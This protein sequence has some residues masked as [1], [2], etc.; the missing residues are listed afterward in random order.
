MG[1]ILKLCLQTALKFMVKYLSATLISFVLLNALLF[2]AGCANII[3]PAGGPMDT[4]P[5]VLVSALP[6]DSTTN[7]S[8][9]KIILNF[10]EYIDLQNTF[11]NVLISPVPRSTPTI[12]SNFKSVS[13]KLKDSLEPNT[14]YTI[15]FGNSLRDINESNIAK[16]FTYVFSTGSSIDTNT[17]RGKVIM[18]ET[19]RVDST[20]IVVLHRNH[21]D[22]AVSL[23][24]P[25]YYARVDGNGMFQFVNLPVSKFSIY[26]IPNN[27]SKLYEDSTKPFAFADSLADSKNVNP[28]ILYAYSR[29]KKDTIDKSKAADKSKESKQV[30][31][32]VNMGGNKQDIL[33]DLSMVFNRKIQ[34]LDSSKIRL[35]DTNYIPFKGY[36]LITDTIK[37]TIA[38]KINWTPGQFY[39]LIIDSNAVADLAGNHL[40]RNDTINFSAKKTDEYGSLK[41]RFTNIDL[42]RN[43]VLQIVQ[44]DQII[45]SVVVKDKEVSKKLFVPGEYDLRILYDTN[46]NGIWDAGKFFGQK[47]QPEIVVPIN[48]KLN[49]RANWDNEKNITL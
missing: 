27:Y 8:G 42:T 12:N 48:T 49:I 31:M 30:K 6:K 1:K 32:Q 16:N 29:P 37:N 7:F 36:S 20:L 35:T 26:A 46:K 9:N 25:R 44:N 14:T 17:I 45:E 23:E 28:V 13:I 3:P 33:Q 43:P 38:V 18:A 21:T 15:N 47:Q 39:K 2:S 19:G 34:I 10:D 41:I 40:S 5:P 22:S 4:L 11:E 24:K